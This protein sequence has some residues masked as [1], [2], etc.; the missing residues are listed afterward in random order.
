MD[1]KTIYMY[2]LHILAGITLGYLLFGC[3]SNKS[4]H[5]G[6]CRSTDSL[7]VK[8]D[9]TNRLLNKSDEYIRFLENDN[10]ILG[11]ALAEKKIE[12]LNK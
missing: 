6:C 4:N 2:M 3:V 5:D 9:S 1:K 12:D 7:Q 8:L 10:H 11:S